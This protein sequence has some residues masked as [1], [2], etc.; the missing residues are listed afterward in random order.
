MLGGNILTITGYGFSAD[1]TVAINSGICDVRS[2][3]PDQ[4]TCTVPAMVSPLSYFLVGSTCL[5]HS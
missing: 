3:Q 2:V 5:L 4:I 1:A